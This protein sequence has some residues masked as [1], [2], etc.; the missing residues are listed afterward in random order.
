MTD[1]LTSPDRINL[2]LNFQNRVGAEKEEVC[3]YLIHLRDKRDS[4]I[5]RWDVLSPARCSSRLPLIFSPL[6]REKDERKDPLLPF[7][8][9]GLGEGDSVVF[10]IMSSKSSKSFSI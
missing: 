4:T 8:A 7:G 10:L 2:N 5:C 6:R 1:L 9:T 3:T